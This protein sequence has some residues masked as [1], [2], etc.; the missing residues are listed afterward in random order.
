MTPQQENE[1]I[2]ERLLGWTHDKVAQGWI[3]PGAAVWERVS[4]P[5]FDQ[6]DTVGMII[7]A[8]D[9][10]GVDVEFGNCVAGW[11]CKIAQDEY[12][13][14]GDNNAFATIREA[15]LKYLALTAP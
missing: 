14:F 9:K 15:A 3:I 4:T 7:E 11:Y 5:H 10:K 12:P 2:C 8:L 6:W 13:P 1:L